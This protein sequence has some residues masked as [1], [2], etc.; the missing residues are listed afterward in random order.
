[1]NKLAVT[2]ARECD[3]QSELRFIESCACVGG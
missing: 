3:A 1:M 2:P